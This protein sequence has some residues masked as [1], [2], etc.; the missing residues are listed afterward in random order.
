MNCH[1][2]SH[3]YKHHD[4]RAFVACDWFGQVGTRVKVPMLGGKPEE[5]PVYEACNCFGWSKT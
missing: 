4:D 2:C 1:E 5:V 3:E